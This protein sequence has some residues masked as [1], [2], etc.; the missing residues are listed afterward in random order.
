MV[1]K[2]YLR[3]LVSLEMTLFGQCDGGGKAAKPPFLPL[4]GMDAVISSKARNL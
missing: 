1:V 4:L 2:E 3:F